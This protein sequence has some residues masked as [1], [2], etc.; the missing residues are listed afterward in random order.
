M[1]DVV[2]V[3]AVRTAV[4]KFG[5][6]LKPLSAADLAVSVMKA[7]LERSGVEA[8]AVDEV[9][10]VCDGLHRPFAVVRLAEAV[11][12]GTRWMDE[13]EAA[14][15]DGEVSLVG[16]LVAGGAPFGAARED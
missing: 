12:E 2:I 3:E 16:V 6:S 13:T 7:A 4:G 10:V 9:A 15:E 11:A 8:D 1:K 5:G 14:R